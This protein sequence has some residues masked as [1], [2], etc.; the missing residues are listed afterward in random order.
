MKK[1]YRLLGVLKNLMK[2]IQNP[3]LQVKNLTLRQM[4]VR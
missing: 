3:T 4:A 2:Y 1:I